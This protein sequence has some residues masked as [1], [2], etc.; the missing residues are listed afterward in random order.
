MASGCS[1]PRALDR[2]FLFLF[3]SFCANPQTIHNQRC[4]ME[5]A[6]PS[7]QVPRP[8]TILNFVCRKCRLSFCDRE[9]G[10]RP[11]EERLLCFPSTG[12]YSRHSSPCV[13]PGSEVPLTGAGGGDHVM[14][15][16]RPQLC[17][18]IPLRTLCYRCFGL[19]I[20]PMVVRGRRGGTG[21]Y[22]SLVG[23]FFCS[24]SRTRSWYTHSLRAEVCCTLKRVA[25]KQ[26]D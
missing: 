3:L 2:P 10:S 17:S 21:G 6:P 16:F 5:E 11:S 8:R 22:R 1:H 18:K 15:Y 24:L 23:C 13:C 25:V 4:F 26:S 19:E 7:R 14:R 9:E 12:D 20:F